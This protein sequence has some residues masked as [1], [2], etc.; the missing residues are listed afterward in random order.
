MHIGLDIHG[1]I[2]H[3][4]DLFKKLSEKWSADGHI[5]H[6]ITG[7]EWSKASQ[8]VGQAGII[9]HHHFSIVD[10]HRAIGTEMWERTDKRGWWMDEQKWNASKGNYAK[11]QN[12]KLH[13]DDSIRYAQYFPEDCAFIYVPVLGFENIYKDCL[14][15]TE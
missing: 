7:Q 5:I 1:V 10:H 11:A 8:A 14:T 12:I 4:T 13:F 9:Y 2:D 15:C 6:I 3:Y